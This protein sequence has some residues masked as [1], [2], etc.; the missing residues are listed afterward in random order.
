MWGRTR[1]L[2]RGLSRSSMTYTL[3]TRKH[4]RVLSSS[5]SS[6][7]LTPSAWRPW[8]AIR[9][10][11]VAGGGSS[12]PRPHESHLRLCA[13]AWG[14]LPQPR[15]RLQPGPDMAFPAG[16]CCRG[17]CSHPCWP[18][19]RSLAWLLPVIVPADSLER[20]LAGHLGPCIAYCHGLGP[21]RRLQGQ[22][23]SCASA[24]PSQGP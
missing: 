24:G 5:S 4:C 11:R 10:G 18:G 12:S 8:P 13:A 6:S 17:C 20:H 1:A 7:S 22:R 16:S 19:Q 9:P 14:P 2:V 3:G 21:W 23:P 15:P